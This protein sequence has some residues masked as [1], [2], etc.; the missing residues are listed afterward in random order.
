MT[1]ESSVKNTSEIVAKRRYC[2]P[3]CPYSTDRRDL[4]TRHENIHRDEKPF[5]C[6]VCEK[7]FNRADHVKKHFLRIHKGVEYDVKLTKRIKGRDYDINKESNN[8]L[9]NN[10]LNHLNETQFNPLLSQLFQYKSAFIN[11]INR[12]VVENETKQQ[13]SSH[14][15]VNN[16]NDNNNNI[17]SVPLMKVQNIDELKDEDFQCEYCGCTFVDYCSLHTHRYLLHRYLLE[18]SNYLPYRCVI[19]GI[20]KITQ[21]S[22]MSHM[23]KHIKKE[24]PITQVNRSNRRTRKQLQPRKIVKFNDLEEYSIEWLDKRCLIR[25]KSFNCKLCHKYFE[26]YT[27]LIQH[28]KFT[29]CIN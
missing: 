6:Y 29:N 18:N 4:Y 26:T 21:R 22:I 28:Q 7:M 5:R 25:A 13:E 19:C 8:D 10:N 2:C 27:Q 23:L 15:L 14:I 20:R 3:K 11:P 24:E 1:S 16:N 17:N 9:N 12:L